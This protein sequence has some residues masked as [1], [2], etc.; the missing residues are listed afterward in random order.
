MFTT[1]AAMAILPSAAEIANNTFNA[2]AASS[3]SG[4][5]FF[6]NGNFVLP[7]QLFLCLDTKLSSLLAAGSL[8]AVDEDLAHW[9]V[10]LL[11]GQCAPIV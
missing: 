9:S 2:I 8:P 10:S 5:T 6:A 4:C 7:V 11:L 1:A 3:H